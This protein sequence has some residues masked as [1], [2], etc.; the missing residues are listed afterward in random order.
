MESKHEV[1]VVEDDKILNKLMCHYVRLA[2]HR[3]YSALDGNSAVASAQEHHP[4]LV[5]LDLMLPDISG[6]EVC[7]QL[8]GDARTQSATIL[9]VTALDDA[10]SRKRGMEC[11]ATEYILKP[12]HPDHLI[13]SIKKHAA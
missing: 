4:T 1:L 3:V 2:G 10:E 11:G 13:E 9:M 6:F 12:F 8:K 5:L 7:L